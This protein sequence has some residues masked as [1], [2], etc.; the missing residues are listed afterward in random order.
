MK[1]IGKQ[2]AAVAFTLCAAV[3]SY[4]GRGGS[5][6]SIV[7]A[8]QSGSQGSIL[9]EVERT[10]EL[11]CPECVPTITALMADSRYPVREV[12]AWWIA[13][14]PGLL[15]QMT[16]Q[17]IGNLASGNSTSVRN[18]A[19]FLGATVQFQS[20]PALRS[21]FANSSLS[22]DAKLAIVRAVGRMAHVSGNVILV[23]AISDSYADVRAAA[24]DAW[25][26]VVNQTTAAPFVSLLNDPDAHVR[27]ETAALMGGFAQREANAALQQIVVNDPDATVR[28]NAAWAL[29]KIG[30]ETSYAALT[31]ATH[32]PSGLVSGVAKAALTTLRAQYQ[33]K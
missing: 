30:S 6:A 20:L 4:A 5:N 3:P 8:V 21:A 10:E 31:T 7:A 12:A 2:L 26:N 28:R 15:N 9:A 18:A 24:V 32:D 14:R 11:I 33:Y 27:A 22:L 23:A 1:N 19:D 29:G 16:T 25:R 13:K 17:M